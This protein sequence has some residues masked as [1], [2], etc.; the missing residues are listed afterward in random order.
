MDEVR[1]LRIAL[2]YVAVLYTLYDLNWMYVQIVCCWF[3][4][5]KLLLYIICRRVP[6]PMCR[7]LAN[8]HRNDVISN[9][10]AVACGIIGQIS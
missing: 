4:G 3:L 8:D 10:A 7:A 1:Y 6:N 5:V 2:L 9:T